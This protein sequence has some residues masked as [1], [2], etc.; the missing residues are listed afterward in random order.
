MRTYVDSGVLIT[1]ARGNALLRAPA[2]EILADPRREFV[3]SEWVK[4]EVLPKARYF[5]RQAEVDFYDLFFGRVKF[6][7]AFE[8]NLLVAAMDE[9]CASGLSA[10]DAIHV[11]LA[12]RSGCEELIT[13]EK[14]SSG[15]HRTGR[16][17]IVSIYPPGQAEA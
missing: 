16:V 3:S 6:W 2:I 13:S 9:A 1:A 4:L 7:A 5:D 14:A 8:P 11:V 15:I 17:R 12:A 10:V